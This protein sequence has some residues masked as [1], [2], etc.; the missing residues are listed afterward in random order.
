[1]DAASWIS[2]AAVCA[3]GAMSPGPSLAVV[4]KNTVGGGRSQG[5]AAGLGHGLGVGIYALGAV[6]GVSALVES[7][8]GLHRGIEVLGAL[9]LLWMGWGALRHAGEG[10]DEHGVAGRSGFSEGFLVA[11]LNPKI[12][13]FFL[14]LLGPFLP[15][16]ATV[17]ERVGVAS[18]AMVIDGA[19]YVLAAAVLAGTG[20]AAWL[21]HK[22]A[23][24]DRGLGVVLIAVAAWLLVG[25]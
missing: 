23:W 18:L 1:M 20:A 4:L 17:G 12:A 3:T 19:W 14:A 10:S 8:P 5:V 15:P 13:V 6:V 25:G 16:G 2:I 21:K 9:Y 7:V 11:F 24:V 22:G